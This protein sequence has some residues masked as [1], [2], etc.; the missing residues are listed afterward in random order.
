M[1]SWTA[2]RY[3]HRTRGRWR[4]QSHCQRLVRIASWVASMRLKRSTS[5]KLFFTPSRRQTSPNTA[6]SKFCPGP[7]SVQLLWCTNVAEQVFIYQVFSG[8]ASGLVRDRVC[9][10]PLGEVIHGHEYVAVPLVRDGK[11]AQDVDAHPLHGGPHLVLL[12][13]GIWAPSWSLLG[14]TGVASVNKK[15]HVLVTPRPEE[16]RPESAEGLGD[17]AKDMQPGIKQ[18]SEG[19]ET[20]GISPNSSWDEPVA[21]HLREERI[22]HHQ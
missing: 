20:P 17:P 5:L 10:W 6:A 11:G 21:K 12:Q 18:L 16:E 1:D 8:V 7:W 14:S 3:T 15:I 9:L 2:V 22:G 13:W 4:S 19:W